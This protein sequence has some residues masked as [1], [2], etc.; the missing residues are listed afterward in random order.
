M[1]LAIRP[2]C[3]PRTAVRFV[4]AASSRNQRATQSPKAAIV[5]QSSGDIGE[6]AIP[7]PSQEHTPRVEPGANPARPP[8]VDVLIHATVT[9]CVLVLASVWFRHLPPWVQDI[10][11][12]SFLLS[13]SF[14][15]SIGVREP[16]IPFGDRCR[17]G[18]ATC[19]MTS[20]V[21]VA[22]CSAVPGPTVPGFA[23]VSR[24]LAPFL[25]IIGFFWFFSLY[26][27][28]TF[29]AQEVSLITKDIACAILA[30]R[31]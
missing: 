8:F 15:A 21:V 29:C 30:R 9:L 7:P 31:A 26:F 10:Q 25:Q 2:S 20:L 1:H 12:C 4:H 16:R 19:A 3:P 5:E 23:D 18:A 28:W 13:A 11:I 24:G 14:G 17:L 22:W 27:A 6:S